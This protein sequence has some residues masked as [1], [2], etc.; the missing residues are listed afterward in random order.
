MV[1]RSLIILLALTVSVSAQR[2]CP[3]NQVNRNGLVGRWLVPGKQTGAV[4]T[5]T[6][7]L[8][9][10]NKGNHGTTVASPN[11][12]V[13]FSRAAMTFNGS[14]QYVSVG[15]MGSFG[16]S[17]NNITV[18]AWVNTSNRT[19]IMGVLGTSDD[20]TT[21]RNALALYVNAKNDQ[22]LLAGSVRV[23]F[24]SNDSTPLKLVGAT[25]ANSV[26]A[27]GW[28]LITAVL[29]AS[30]NTIII[31]VDGVSKTVTYNVQAT[32]AN[33]ANFS[34]PMEVGAM[35][36]GYYVDYYFNGSIDDVRIYNRT[37]SASEVRAIYQGE[38]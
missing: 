11:Y 14:S 2:I 34:N 32:P 8:D 13:I 31:Y 15:T 37:L 22:T 4:A 24:I 5:P 1:I 16:S 17:R 28:H 18:S 19:N 21:G 30:T 27:D 3:P 38:Q 12:G 23:A 9:D 10:S 26:P 25:D 35:Y 6:R 33:F 20:Y 36:R 7:C 29:T